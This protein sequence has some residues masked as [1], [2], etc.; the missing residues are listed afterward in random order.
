MNKSLVV[1]NWK[2]NC[3]LEEAITLAKEISKALNELKGVEIVL[4]PPYPYLFAVKNEIENSSIRLGSQNLYWEE[5]GAFT[6]EISVT[7]ISEICEYVIIGHSE[8][9]QIFG[10]TDEIVNKKL[11]SA[12]RFGI[13]PI[14]CVGENLVQRENGEA[15]S[16][17]SRQ[18]EA[19]LDGIQSPDGLAVA[20]EPIWAIGTGIPA[21]PEIVSE[22][23]GGTITK[24]LNK[25]YGEERTAQI[26]LL[27]GGSVSGQN[28]ESF[29]ALDCINGALVGGASLRSNEF[30]DIA[31]I[32]SRIKTSG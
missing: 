6:G 17:V 12:I 7:M 28:I 21:T 30:S 5:K 32:T 23:M 10:E 18:I 15:A 27:Y 2:M 16:V 8:R 29:A 3:G 26:P 31:S 9:R 25:L 22:V 24:T 4:C 14:L 20:Y 1:G 11:S 19:G 13:S